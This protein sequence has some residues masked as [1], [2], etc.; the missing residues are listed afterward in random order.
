MIMIMGFVL[1]ILGMEAENVIYNAVSMFMWIVVM[2]GQL[3]I[4]TP[5]IV[6]AFDEPGMLAVALAFIFVNVLLIIY[7]FTDLKEMIRYRLR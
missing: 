3:Y 5:G 4:E 6:D 1:F 2:A 7:N